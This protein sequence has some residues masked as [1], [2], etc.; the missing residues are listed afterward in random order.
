MGIKHSCPV[1][2]FM[3]Y[4][5]AIIP[6]MFDDSLSYYEALCALNRFIQKNLVEVINNNAAVTQEYIKLV[7]EL[8]EYVEHYFD[9]LDVQEEV[10]NKL[11]AM[12]E[13]GTLGELINQVLFESKMSAY[14]PLSTD[15]KLEY[16]GQENQQAFC[17]TVDGKFVT[18]K[19]GA[20][21][22][23]NVLYEWNED[24][25]LLRS[26]T[27]TAYHP[28]N[29]IYV[30]GY[31]YVANAY[32]TD[33]ENNTSTV[34]II[35]KINYSNF[36][37]EEITLTHP[38]SK[39]AYHDSKFYCASPDNYLRIYN[40]D[41]TNLIST[42]ELPTFGDIYQ[43]MQVN[44]H[45]IILSCSYSFIVFLNHD[46]SL[47]KILNI[48]NFDFITSGEL[49]DIDLYD[50]K[51][52]LNTTRTLGGN[53]SYWF[54]GS[55]DYSNG[56]VNSV[57]LNQNINPYTNKILYV[58]SSY[59]GVKQ[60]GTQT[61]PFTDI[62]QA[63]FVIFNPYILGLT[64]SVYNGTYKKVKLNNIGK[65]LTI[66]GRGQKVNTFVAG[67][68]ITNCTNVVLDNFTV[69]AIYDSSDNNYGL[70]ATNSNIH[71]NNVAFSV[72]NSIKFSYGNLYTYNLGVTGS[73]SMDVS[74]ARYLSDSVPTNYHKGYTVQFNHKVVLFES[75]DGVDITSNINFSNYTVSRYK[76]LK[77]LLK[78]TSAAT[79]TVWYRDLYV[80]V[81][82]GTRK[83]DFFLKNAGDNVLYW[84]IL[85]LGFNFTNN[86]ISGSSQWTTNL[87]GTNVSTA[88][89]PVIKLL[90]VE[91]I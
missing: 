58:N 16:S 30:D 43:G 9:N 64:I 66:V 71:I 74:Y 38:T 28:N 48:R 33:S 55:F 56:N 24:G 45:H 46:L 41:F 50:G 5:S 6:T 70:V 61:N 31:L 73:N 54:I 57:I 89:Q 8:K 88:N 34:N 90:R 91:E 15:V 65:P 3:R 85:T 78:V 62:E 86:R 14:K 32:A 69:N 67:L 1:P 53:R 13:D 39:I 82:N 72:D 17:H 7:D 37:T 52:Y 11:D 25:T 36:T 12:A 42:S 40:S 76:T 75:E 2:P 20:D 44:D 80:D 87:D 79:A 77:L 29:V 4:C 10:N 18:I 35:T 59:T 26:L 84:T 27:F 60:I 68:W 83:Y 47:D 19:I 81:V 51:L 22:D 21:D 23:S 63:L 49:Q